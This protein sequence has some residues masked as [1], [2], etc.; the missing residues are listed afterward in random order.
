[1]EKNARC[2]GTATVEAALLFP[3]ITALC[4]SGFSLLTVWYGQWK[5]SGDIHCQLELEAQ[6]KR[7]R[8]GTLAAIP[9]VFLS[10]ERQEGGKTYQRYYFSR[11]AYKVHW[12]QA[13]ELIGANGSGE[14]EHGREDHGRED[15]E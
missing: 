13:W 2:R 4:I 7:E 12:K 5:E 3:L 1:M 15:H 11:S 14:E 9:G 6:E 8:R 10:V